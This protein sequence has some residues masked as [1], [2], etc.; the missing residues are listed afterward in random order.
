M[1]IFQRIFYLIGEFWA[2]YVERDDERKWMK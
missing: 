2:K 1:N